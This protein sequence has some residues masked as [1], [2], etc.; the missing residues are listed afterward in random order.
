LAEVRTE[1]DTACAPLGYWLAGPLGVAV[2]LLAG[3]V[4]F[5]IGLM[6]AERRHGL[7]TLGSDLLAVAAAVAMIAAV[8]GVRVWLDLPI[9]GL[10][11]WLP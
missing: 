8:A 7:L 9:R 2:A 11:G 5:W 6:W 4:W 10:E 1:L 3:T